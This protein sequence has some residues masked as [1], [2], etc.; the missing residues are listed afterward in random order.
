MVDE[1]QRILSEAIGRPLRMVIAS[2]HVF[3]GERQDEEP[4]QLWLSFEGAAPIRLSGASDGGRILADRT[5]PEPA[6]MQ[7]SG[8]VILIDASR[9]TAF[10]DVIGRKLEGA[11]LV[12]S[13]PEEI[14][15]LRFDFGLALKPVVF[16]W[17]DELHVV[18]DYPP[19]VW[20]E[21]IWET[22][23]R[24]VALK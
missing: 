8:E 22:R 24:P 12:E 14:I 19:D 5:P 2:I 10:A 21:G 23:M 7:E 18:D 4:L 15:G 17:G 3:E 13:P 9:S 6:D 16:N 20:G 11:W 1:T